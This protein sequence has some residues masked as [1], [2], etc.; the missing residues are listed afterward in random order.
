M[1][2]QAG[3]ECLRLCLKKPENKQASKHINKQMLLEELRR[4]KGIELLMKMEL[5]PCGGASERL[6]MAPSG[7]PAQ[8][9][10]RN[11]GV[12]TIPESW[13]RLRS[14]LGGTGIP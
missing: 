1:E 7:F 8:E 14:E 3:L 13:P 2:F 4:R 12:Q 9:E 11:C 6:Q 5:P 10:G